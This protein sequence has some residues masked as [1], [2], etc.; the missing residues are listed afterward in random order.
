MKFDGKPLRKSWVLPVLSRSIDAPTSTEGLYCLHEAT[1]SVCVTGIDH[2]VWTAY[3]FIDTYFGSKET[4]DRYHQLRGTTGRHKGRA[5]PL[6]AGRNAD[7]PL[8]TPREYFFKVLENRM[9]QVLREWNEI[10]DKVEEKVKKYVQC[11]SSAN[12][13]AFSFLDR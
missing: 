10:V 13:G 6:T 4:V 11:S 1:I 8:W 7:E 2:W 5:D 9:K 12:K 3:G